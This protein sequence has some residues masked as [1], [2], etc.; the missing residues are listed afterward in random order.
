MKMRQELCVQRSEEVRMRWRKKL[1]GRGRRPFQEEVKTTATG[2]AVY[3]LLEEEK[4]DAAAASQK[5]K[6]CKERRRRV[7]DGEEDKQNA[8][9]QCCKQKNTKRVLDDKGK[10]R[11]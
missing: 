2:N 7:E 8:E 4:K 10:V 9:E 1:I 11:V 5:K 6:T 3:E